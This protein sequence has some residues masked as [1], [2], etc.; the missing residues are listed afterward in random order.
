MMNSYKEKD[1]AYFMSRFPAVA[2][3]IIDSDYISSCN[4]SMN[5]FPVVLNADYELWMAMRIPISSYLCIKSTTQGG[6][7]FDT[8][9]FYDT[10]ADAI[11]QR[12]LSRNTEGIDNLVAYI[13][14][15]LQKHNVNPNII[16]R[17]FMA[18][19]RDTWF[20]YKSFWVTMLAYWMLVTTGQIVE[21]DQWDT[22]RREP[23]LV[24]VKKIYSLV[25]DT[26][27]KRWTFLWPLRYKHTHP[28]YFTNHEIVNLYDYNTDILPVDIVVVN[29]WSWYEWDT[30]IQAIDEFHRSRAKHVEAVWGT[31]Q[32]NYLN[33]FAY[34]LKAEFINA[35]EKLVHNQNNDMY[36][37]KLMTTIDNINSFA[38]IIEW[39]NKMIEWIMELIKEKKSFEN[40]YIGILPVTS[41]QYADNIMIIANKNRSRKTIDAIIEELNKRNSCAIEYVSWVDKDYKTGIKIE[42]YP[43]SDIY[44]PGYESYDCAVKSADGKVVYKKYGDIASEYKDY[45]V[46]DSIANKIYKDGNPIDSD[47]LPSQVYTIAVLKILLDQPNKRISNK[48]LPISAY[49]KS[50]NQ[51]SGKILSPLKKLTNEL[52]W[53]PIQIYVTGTIYDFEI[54]IAS[55]SDAF[56][57]I[58]KK[59]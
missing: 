59:I 36:V 9:I 2:N 42:H 4:F 3:L 7:Q 19:D 56:I 32:E 15:Y 24:L 25:G 27:F 30:S 23:I 48:K 13:T 49:S 28:V 47:M 20:W 46:I 6:V 57:F 50:M 51:F 22:K 17:I 45:L 40:E 18:R 1:L 33:N 34:C 58:E 54:K 10:Y 11:H 52:L 16:I 21:H 31:Y 35:Y 55:S 5:F 8:S 39:P 41:N 29:F 44:L 43:I 38:E 12:P 53:S 26:E 37:Q 14:K